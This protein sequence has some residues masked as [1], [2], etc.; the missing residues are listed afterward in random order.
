M[1]SLI[2]FIPSVERLNQETLNSYGLSHISK[3]SISNSATTKAINNLPGFLF[4]HA[5]ATNKLG[6]RPESQ[7]W[8]VIKI[9]DSK[10]IYIGYD[11]DAKPILNNFKKKNVELTEGFELKLNDGNTYKF[12]RAQYIPQSFEFSPDGEI[13]RGLSEKYKGIVDIADKYYKKFNNGFKEVNED[14]DEVF[15]FDEV[16]MMKDVSALLSTYYKLSYIE[17]VYFKLFDSV[18]MVNILKKFLGFDLIEEIEKE[19]SLQAEAEKKSVSTS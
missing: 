18:N 3:A 19:L 8:Q 13:V 5:E 17:C 7:T 10:K 16:D 15:V 12:P 2:Y 14:G 9:D 1:N 6:Y 11:N 4:Q